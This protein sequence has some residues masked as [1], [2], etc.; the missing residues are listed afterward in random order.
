MTRRRL[1]VRTLGL[2][3]ALV[4]VGA[5]AACGGGGDPAPGDKVTVTIPAGATAAQ[6][7]QLLEEA[8]VVASADG[9]VERLVAEGQGEGFKPG[10]YAL[11][12]NEAFDRIV[13]QLNS[14]PSADA[15][16][17][18]IPEGYAIW[19]IKAAVKKVGI[20]PAQYQA[21]LDAHQPPQGFLTGGEQAAT[22]EGFL[23]P[24]TYDVAVPADAD[25]LVTD[26]LAAFSDNWASIDMTYA[27]SKNL[28]RYDVLKIASLSERE[29]QAQDDR[30]KIASVIYNRLR[31][32]M[33]LGIDAS[34]QYGLGS[35]DELTGTDLESDSP[36]NLRR[37]KGLPPTPICN[38]GL[39]SM[40]AAANPAKTD[41]LYYYAI[42]GDPEGRH[43]F[44]DSYDAFLQY[45]KEHPYS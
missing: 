4:L 18:T 40:Q 35:W 6:I 23:F 1:L 5:V 20:K 41:Y 33:S 10:T 15:A 12:T 13:F 36:F 45:Q 17:L 11:R 43:W 44:T 24:A 3:A 42:K 31:A 29:A 34:V 25:A 7:A 9:F 39:A 30:A 21:A 37:F 19:D 26:Q 16:R 27:S 2:L 14:G 28:T 8:G 22:L 38:P 32:D